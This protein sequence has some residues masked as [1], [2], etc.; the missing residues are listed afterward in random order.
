MM[1]MRDIDFDAVAKL[2]VGLSTPPVR[3]GVILATEFGVSHA[4]ISRPCTLGMCRRL[5]VVPDGQEAETE[6]EFSRNCLL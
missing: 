5:A 2:G 3:E 4:S 6:L 1:S